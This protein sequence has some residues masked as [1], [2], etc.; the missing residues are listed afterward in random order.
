MFNCEE[1]WQMGKL[2]RLYPKIACF[3]LNVQ[4]NRTFDTK[5]YKI[6]NAIGDSVFVCDQYIL[7]IDL[8][9]GGK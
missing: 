7:V 2:N 4:V 1:S 8:K 6:L 3:G 9:I 5:C